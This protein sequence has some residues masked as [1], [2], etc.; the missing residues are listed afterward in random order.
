MAKEPPGGVYFEPQ[1]RIYA[2]RALEVLRGVLVRSKAKEVP[3]SE[4]QALRDREI[5]II[6][7]ALRRFL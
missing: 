2:K 3:G 5:A 4:V 7:A 6:D 1:E